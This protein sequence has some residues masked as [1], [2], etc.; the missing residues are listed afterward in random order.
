VTNHTASQLDALLAD[1]AR[2]AEVPVEGIPAL[3]GDIERLKAALWVQLLRRSTE[4]GNGHKENA[5]AKLLT[6]SQAAELAN[7]PVSWIRAAARRGELPCV[8][9]GRRYVRFRRA[10]LLQL[11]EGTKP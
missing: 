10:D 1:P 6:A 3:L 8:K 4:S 5:D 2:A 7:A 9:I 11:S